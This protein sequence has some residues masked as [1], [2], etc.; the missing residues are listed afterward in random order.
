MIR[1][2]LFSEAIPKHGFLYAD[3][4]QVYEYGEEGYDH[5]R[6]GG[7]QEKSHAKQ[8][9]HETDVHRVS[10]VTVDPGRQ[11]G[12]RFLEWLDGCVMAL[13]KPVGGQIE[14]NTDRKGQQSYEVCGVREDPAP[15]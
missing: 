15:R 4:H 3:V 12:C 7:A 11:K 5:E 8:K 10:S 2:P 6:T 1:N 14:I 9:K 13:E